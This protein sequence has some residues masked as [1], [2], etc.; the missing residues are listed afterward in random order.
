MIQFGS[1]RRSVYITGVTCD[2]PAELSEATGNGRGIRVLTIRRVPP[3]QL[4][5]SFGRFRSHASAR[6]GLTPS[7]TCS[8]RI[9][10]LLLGCKKP[11]GHKSRS[12]GCAENPWA[13]RAVGSAR[14]TRHPLGSESASCGFYCP[15]NETSLG[16]LCRRRCLFPG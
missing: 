6:F 16:R 8:N 15:G 7:R 12:C 11:I 5:R 2:S 1:E 3:Q 9:S 13:A 10:R 4:H 14:E